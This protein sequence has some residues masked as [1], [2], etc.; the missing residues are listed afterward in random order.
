MIEVEIITL[1]GYKESWLE[2]QADTVEEL[3]TLIDPLQLTS[4]MKSS[5]LR[6]LEVKY[7]S[8]DDRTRLAIKCFNVGIM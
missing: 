3:R 5:R 1:N 2:F 7:P 4:T 8:R 6:G